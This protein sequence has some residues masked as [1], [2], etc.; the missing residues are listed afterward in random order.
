MKIK[1]IGLMSSE[2]LVNMGSASHVR[3]E[4]AEAIKAELEKRSKR[5]RLHEQIIELGSNLE[6]KQ[7]HQETLLKEWTPA[8][9]NW[10]GY[11]PHKRQAE[12]HKS[13]KR[14]R[15]FIAGFKS[16]KSLSGA[17]ELIR[18]S[19]MAKHRDILW[20]VAPTF[21]LLN[22]AKDNLEMYFE[23][24]EGYVVKHSVKDATYYLANG[25]RIELKS[26]H[27]SDHLRGPNVVDMWIDEGGYVKDEAWGVLRAK[28][29]ATKGNIFTTTTPNGR[30]W[31]WLECR[32]GGLSSSEPYTTIE[33]DDYFV[34]HWPTSEFPWVDDDELKQIKEGTTNLEYARD[35]EASFATSAGTVFSNVEECF[36]QQR[37]ERPDK[38]AQLVAGV[39]LAKVQDFS[40]A[41]VMDGDGNVHHVERWRDMEWAVQKQRIK[42]ICGEWNA[43]CCLDVSNVGSTIDEELRSMKLEVFQIQLNSA[44]VKDDLIT[45]LRIALEGRH[46]RIPN[47][48][49]PWASIDCDHLYQELKNYTAS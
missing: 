26:A 39:D 21:Q 43:I 41:V 14:F 38:K 47:P 22:T 13:K 27:I 29:I 19:L 30:N 12:F 24:N 17:V 36:L 15:L 6:D 1:N 34:S 11:K 37:P 20:V 4:K 40:A 8:T 18:R 35:Y 44:Q 48:H 28:I 25:A 3:I 23:A 16:G 9:F 10:L 2:A 5:T 46:I 31:V 32:K 7:E 42:R 45:A 49:R 33:K